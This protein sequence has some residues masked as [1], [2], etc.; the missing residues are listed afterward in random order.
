MIT[1]KLDMDELAEPRDAHQQ[2]QLQVQE[3]LVFGQSEP[4][5]ERPGLVSRGL[6][7]GMGPC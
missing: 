7:S 3:E 5:D 4:V 6:A 2:E 1:V